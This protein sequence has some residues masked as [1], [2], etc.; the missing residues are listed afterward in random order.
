MKLK[1]NFLLLIA[2]ISFSLVACKKDHDEIKLVTLDVTLARGTNYQLNLSQYGDA[3]DVA[4]IVSQATDFTTSEIVN[5]PATSW[6][7][8]KYTAAST[9][10]VPAISSDKVVLKVSESSGGGHCGSKETDITINFTL[11]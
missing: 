9:P 3:D 4:S 5:D 8:Y 2:V 11:Q 10:K 6:Y 1:L 7:V